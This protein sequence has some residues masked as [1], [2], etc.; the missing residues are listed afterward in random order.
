MAFYIDLHRLED[1][2]QR[3]LVHPV[4]TGKVMLYGSSFYTNW[5]YDRAREQLSRA[6]GGKLDIINHGFGGATIDELL[7]NY[8]RLVK[9]YKPSAMVLRTGYNELS[10]GLNPEQSVFML[11]RLLEWSTKDNPEVKILIMKVFD[12]RHASP[13]LYEQIKEYN[14]LMEQRLSDLENVQLFDINPFFYTDPAN[15]GIRQNFRDVFV[16][17]GL[18]LTDEAYE[19]MAVYFGKLLLEKLDLN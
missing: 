1:Q 13:K 10:W 16:A 6:T 18:H 19:E 4:T 12:T 17:D 3:I 5:G 8:N 15:I 7:Y 14:A 11:E 2:I 9:P